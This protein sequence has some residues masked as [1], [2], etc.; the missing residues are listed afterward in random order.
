MNL[1]I[2]DLSSVISL[3][4]SLGIVSALLQWLRDVALDQLTARMPDAQRNAILRALLILLNY[5]GVLGLSLLMGQPMSSALLLSAGF[6]AFVAAGGSHVL[7]SYVQKPASQRYGVPDAPAPK[8][9]PDPTPTPPP[10]DEPASAALS[11]AA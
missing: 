5:G 6:A 11:L 4:A 7:Y 10:T 9:E 2:I 1:N 8:V 3:L